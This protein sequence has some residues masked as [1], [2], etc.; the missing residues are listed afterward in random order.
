MYSIGS[1]QEIIIIDYMILRGKRRKVV[2]LAFFKPGD[3]AEWTH[4]FAGSSSH[5]IA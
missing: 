2:K 1:G 5:F 4:N 3:Y